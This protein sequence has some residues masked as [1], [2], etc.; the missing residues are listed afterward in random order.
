MTSC[1]I[2]IIGKMSSK[3]VK[4][5]SSS[6]SSSSSKNGSSN[7]S[8]FIGSKDRPR[9]RVFPV[10][11]PTE[12]AGFLSFPSASKMA[13]ETSALAAATAAAPFLAGLLQLEW[14]ISLHYVS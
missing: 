8:E 3:R 1:D 7:N 4:S 9:F 13:R 12:A 11:S 5:M 10:V 2:A 6:L 14:L